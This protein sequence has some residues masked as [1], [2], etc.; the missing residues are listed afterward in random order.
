MTL[1]YTD[2]PIPPNSSAKFAAW[3]QNVDEQISRITRTRQSKYV[4]ELTGTTDASGFL[5]F[6][7][8]AQI[9]PTAIIV[10]VT[11]PTLPTSTWCNY[12]D[13]I[14]DSTARARF[15]ESSAGSVVSHA[16]SSTTFFAWV[17]A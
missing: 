14:G 9:A 5:T 7:H 8:D 4:L 11:E 12:V 1:G 13:Q 16:N 6:S 2:A 17:I 3:K 15:L 10:Q